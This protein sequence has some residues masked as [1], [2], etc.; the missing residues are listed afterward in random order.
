MKSILGVILAGSFLLV[1]TALGQDAA[2]GEKLFSTKCKSCHGTAGQGNPA[3]AKSL[4]VT[5][6]DLKSAE[7]QKQSDADLK[8]LAMGGQG[9]KKPLKTVTPVE[10]DDVIAFVRK[11]K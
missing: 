1:S 5:F 9:K 8:K 2:K 4:G 3:I 11:M 6:R 10:L 7:V